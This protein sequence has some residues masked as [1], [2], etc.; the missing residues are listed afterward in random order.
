MKRIVRVRRASIL[1]SGRECDDKAGQ[2]GSLIEEIEMELKHN[3]RQS[4]YKPEKHE[5][6]RML[7]NSTGDD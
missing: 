6:N 5:A 2:K 4:V 7:R 1:I 3:N